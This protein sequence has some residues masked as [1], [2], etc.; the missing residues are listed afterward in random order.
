[1]VNMEG[2]SNYAN[3]ADIKGRDKVGSKKA[4]TEFDLVCNR[5]TGLWHYGE[6]GFAQ[7][8]SWIY[9]GV[10]VPG[11]TEKSWLKDESTWVVS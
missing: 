5:I 6:E 11:S 8:I 3:F 1:M 2:Q 9:I 10:D 7:Q 4:W